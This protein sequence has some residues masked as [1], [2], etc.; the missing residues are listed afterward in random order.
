M[1]TNVPLLIVPFIVYN[2]Q[3]FF[4]GGIRSH[5]YPWVGLAIF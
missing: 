4:G 5:D 1:L 3:I 2:I